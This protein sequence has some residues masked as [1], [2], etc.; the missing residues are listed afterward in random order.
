MKLNWEKVRQVE[1]REYDLGALTEPLCAWYAGNKRSMPW[2]EDATPYHV[3]LSEIMLQQTRIEAARAYYERFIAR[4][5]DVQALAGVSEE[6]LLKLWEGLGYYN[7]ARNLQKTARLLVERFDGNLPADYDLLLE[8]PGIGSYTAGAIASIAYAIPAPAV[9][10]NVLRVTMRYLNCDDD[11]MKQSVRRKMERA[12][13]KV[14]PKDCPGE[15]NQALMELGEVI[16]IPGGRPQCG[17]CPVRS[18]CRGHQAGREMELPKKAEKKKRRVEKKTILLLRQGDKIGIRQREATGLLAGMWEF[19]S[20]EGHKTLP[21]M[22]EWLGQQGLGNAV[23]KRLQEG[24]HIFSHVEWQMRGYELILPED[25][26]QHIVDGLV[27]CDRTKLEKQYPIPVAF[28]IFL[29]RI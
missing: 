25:Q 17:Q 24:K 14:I 28:H 19:P 2:R 15:F 18:Q 26:T 23:V 9:D 21:W 11:I 16:C 1:N 29:H 22:K 13:M 6:E 4:L 12:I 10:G 27:W 20:L 7:R 5:P 3:W 8:L